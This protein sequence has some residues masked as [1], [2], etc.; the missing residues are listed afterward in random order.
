LTST[1]FEPFLSTVVLASISIKNGFDL[2]Y[3]SILR[4]NHILG[5]N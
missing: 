1:D 5:T 3:P 2:H 4:H